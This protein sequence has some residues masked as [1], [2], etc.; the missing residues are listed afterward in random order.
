MASQL[1]KIKKN[2]QAGKISVPKDPHRPNAG[3]Y[4]DSIIH[5]ELSEH[6]PDNLEE[7]ESQISKLTNRM[8]ET[9]WLIGSRLSVIK[10][11]YLS[12]LG[13]L[14]ITEYA[15]EKF[16]LSSDMTSRFV[17]I[18]KNFT[19]A[20][21]RQFGSKLRLLSSLDPLEM[22]KYL[23]WMKEE[24]PTYRE[25]ESKLK[26]DKGQKL[27]RP[28]KE[29]SLTKTTLTVDFKKLGVSIGS[30]KSQEFLQKLQ[31]LIMEYSD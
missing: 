18:A 20:D 26:E 6:I 14:S 22:K 25:I 9:A 13:Y 15:N 8:W 7:I 27:G 21:A 24:N 5:A 2:M 17:F 19:I 3:G 30:E 1:D 23:E 31:E 12:A 4:E 10:E 11:K 28:K 29:I 16:E